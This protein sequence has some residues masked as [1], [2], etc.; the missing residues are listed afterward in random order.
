M[1]ISK[2][3]GIGLA[4]AALV[5]LFWLSRFTADITH[6]ADFNI[7]QIPS[8]NGAW[9][10]ETFQRIDS[11]LGD[12][13]MSD[14]V[15]IW[16]K[17]TIKLFSKEHVF[18]GHCR[19]RSGSRGQGKSVGLTVEWMDQSTIEIRCSEFF[20]VFEKKEK[21]DEITVKFVGRF[22]LPEDNK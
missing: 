8:P 10:A 14:N 2:K 17:D 15:L 22:A 13:S 11:R 1:K 9:I 3:Q 18:G 6:F 5:F 20:S 21:L 19:R 4:I 16:R 7:S 12:S